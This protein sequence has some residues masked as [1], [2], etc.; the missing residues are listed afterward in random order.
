MIMTRE[1]TFLEFRN[2]FIKYC[3]RCMSFNRFARICFLFPVSIHWVTYAPNTGFAI[4]PYLWE[5]CP[6]LL[7]PDKVFVAS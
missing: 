2:H 6:K 5:Y 4:R 1:M 7:T 3:H